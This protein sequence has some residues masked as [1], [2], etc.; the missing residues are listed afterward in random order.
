V[1]LNLILEEVVEDRAQAK[2]DAAMLDISP[3]R[4]TV[5]RRRWDP[6]HETHHQLGLRKGGSASRAARVRALAAWLGGLQHKE[7]L[8]LKDYVP[9]HVVMDDSFHYR[10]HFDR[11]EED[12][13]EKREADNLRSKP[14]YRST[15]QG[16]VFS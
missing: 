15:E 16:P 6:F 7:L 13:P 4:L 2:V 1:A 5:L 14:R 10:D 9:V 8:F 12:S 11:S 3:T